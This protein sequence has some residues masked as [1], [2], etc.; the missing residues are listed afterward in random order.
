MPRWYCSTCALGHFLDGFGQHRHRLGILA[1]RIQHPA[2]SIEERGVRRLRKS[3]GQ[4]FRPRQ[5][6]VVLA[7]SGE[8]HGEVVR[9]D[10][11]ARVG[12][13]HRLVL[14]DRL[15]R[16]PLLLEQRGQ[17]DHQRRGTPGRSDALAKYRDRRLDVAL[18]E[19]RTGLAAV[20]LPVR[21]RER[22][23]GRETIGGL[24]GLLLPLLHQA[25]KVVTQ[26][27][28]GLQRLDRIGGLERGVE[29]LGARLHAI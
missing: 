3:P 25:R 8:Q 10:V 1:A 29:I 7:I 6:L 27:Q 28:L 18:R 11:A 26:R 24:G 12:R 15:L 22:C 13:K 23:R 21:R 5:A 19:L 14:R 2:V 9:G 16:A 20:G 4:F 17:V